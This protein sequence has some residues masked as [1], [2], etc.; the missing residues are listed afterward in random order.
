VKHFGG[1]ESDNQ[2]T[3]IVREYKWDMGLF[4]SD[5]Y[6]DSNIISTWCQ[7][8]GGFIAAAQ[9]IKERLIGT[10]FEKMTTYKYVHYL[11][12]DVDKYV[13]VPFGL[14]DEELERTFNVFG[15]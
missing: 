6:K 8:R 13:P 3:N 12:G 10:V 1:I 4:E 15:R 9:E 2:L 11:Q 7:V 14:T 5:I